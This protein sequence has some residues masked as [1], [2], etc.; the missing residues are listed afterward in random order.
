MLYLIDWLG[1]IYLG[2]KHNVVTRLRT[3][4]MT[5]RPNLKVLAE[6]AGVSTATASQ[7]M[8]G[9]GRISEL[10]R[11]KVM[12]AAKQ[13]YY[14]PD[15][16]AASMRSGEC[17]EIG[18]II[19]EISNPFNAEVISGVSDHLEKNGYL[20]SV[21]DS[22]NEIGRQKRNLE[23]FI[24]SS[25]G[26]LIWVPAH[27][28]PKDAVDMI[29]AHSI[30]TVTFLR[31]PKF[32]QFDHVGIYN[33]EASQL[34][35]EHL[36]TFGHQFIAYFG[37]DV[38]SEVCGERVAGYKKAMEKHKIA[39]TIVWS[40]E[41][42]KASGVA[43]LAELR[44]EHPEV[45]G[46]VCNGDMVALGACHALLKAN[47]VVGQ[48]MSIV[49]FDDVQDAALSTPGLT[50]MSSKPYNLGE[51]LGKSILL[52]INQIHRPFQTSLIEAKLVVRQTTGQCITQS[53]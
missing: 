49:G 16:R 4:R 41:D 51:L 27:D 35:T 9:V 8:R 18:M 2:Y 22:R 52:R 1:P 23:A 15:G 6:T 36:I 21:L 10:T 47:L 48:D 44:L 3:Y 26:G 45:T 46:L 17:R 13:L 50:T 14:V 29:K 5:K 38:R 40:A 28:T 34:A 43:A 11:L 25:R 42:N 20:V 19:H 37:G 31:K 24:R 7:V 39:K 32:G 30:P 12:E 33:T 53:L